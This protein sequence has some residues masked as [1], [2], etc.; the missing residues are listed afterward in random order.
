[1]EKKKRK[2]TFRRLGSLILLL[3]FMMLVK[4]VQASSDIDLEKKSQLT[5]QYVVEN[6][7]F[8][9][10]KVANV[11]KKVTFT[12]TEAFKEYP[13][14]MNDLDAEGFKLLAD[15]LAAYV[16]RDKIE[17]ISQ[18][19]TNEDN[20]IVWDE[21]T[22]GLYLVIGEAVTDENGIKYIPSA[23]LICLPNRADDT[24]WNYAPTIHLKYT[25]EFEE[26][27][28]KDIIDYK[29]VKVWKDSSQ[30]EER[31]QSVTIQLLQDGELFDTVVLNKDNSW[32]YLWEGL[33]NAYSWSVVEKDVPDGYTVTTTLEQQTFIVT[34]TAEKIEISG[35]DN[36]IPQTGQ[37]WWPI[38]ILTM[39]GMVF[40]LLGWVRR[41]S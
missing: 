22:V 32:T 30:K 38:P 1:M 12:P 16:E 2:R 25:N 28:L 27:L 40:F 13:V 17:P 14:I 6:A 36:M 5:I 21:L 29:V 15:T 35:D 9:L 41:K 20:Q 39:I 7:E 33:N 26:D 3:F 4:P 18:K 31:P 24:T 11:D 10:Y 37:L 8:S 23:S 19:L 34:N